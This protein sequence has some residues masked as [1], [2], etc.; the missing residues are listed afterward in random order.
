MFSYPDLGTGRHPRTVPTRRAP[1]WLHDGLEDLRFEAEEYRIGMLIP[2]SGTAGIW[3]PSCLACA[4]LATEE[5]NAAGGHDGRKVCLTVLD[6]SDESRD[7][8]D[9]LQS[10][11]DQGAIESIVGMHTS[12]VR[13][14]VTAQLRG[15]VPFIYTP[16]YEGGVL[17]AG[18]MAIGETPRHQLLPALDALTERYRLRRW[19]LVGN[20]YCWP[21]RSHALATDTLRRAGCEVVGSCYLPMGSV[22]VEQQIDQVRR[23]NAQAVLMSL[24]G[25]DAVE[26]SRAFGESGLASKVIRLSCA[27]EENGL[28][29]IGPEYT[30]GV[31]VSSAYFASLQNDRNGAFR[32][33]YWSRFGERAPVLNALGQST[34]EGVAFLRGFL[35]RRRKRAASI[36]FGSVRSLLWRSNIDKTMPI[37]LAQAEGM[38]FRVVRTLHTLR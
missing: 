35:E 21:R 22:D 12:S 5:W 36:D 19:Y 13:E 3:G 7:L 25:Q 33:R 14:R 37:Y 9:D 17:P 30:E 11:I 6:A 24:V 23:S 10:L 18:V 34:Y 8:E 20:D 28:L 16:L 15:A 4:T 32:E 31:F 38:S 26:F 29:A 27:V 1:R 2:M